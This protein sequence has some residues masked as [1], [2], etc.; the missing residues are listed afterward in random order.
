MTSSHWTFCYCVLFYIYFCTWI[1]TKYKNA[2]VSC[3]MISFYLYVHLQAMLLDSLSTLMFLR[4][5][6]NCLAVLVDLPKKMTQVSPIAR[7]FSATA[8]FNWSDTVS[9][10]IGMF[11]MFVILV[12][13][14]RK[15]V[16]LFKKC[17]LWLPL[18]LQ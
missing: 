4:S 5:A 3:I 17:L 14:L 2:D 7:S 15:P 9:L 10:W 12:L 6:H 18:H 1:F 8:N 16:C 13:C 11:K